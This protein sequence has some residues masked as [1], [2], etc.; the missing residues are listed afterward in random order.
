[1]SRG[2]FFSTFSTWSKAINSQD[3]DN[4]GTGV[5]P[6]QNRGL[7]IYHPGH[8]WLATVNYEL[9]F[10]AGKRATR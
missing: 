5:A 8:R 10:G 2:L 7:E 4:D 1:M 9:L 6:L 3:N